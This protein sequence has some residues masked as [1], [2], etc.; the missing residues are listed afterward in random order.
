MLVIALPVKTQNSSQESKHPA[1][2]ANG[3]WQ[4]GHRRMGRPKAM[5]FL[6]L[7]VF[8]LFPSFGA[9][10]LIEPDFLRWFDAED[11][12]SALGMIKLEQWIAL[13]LLLAHGVFGWLAWH[14]RRHEPFQEIVDGNEPNPNHDLKKLY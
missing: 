14:Y 8:W 10:W 13:A 4:D 7:S 12:L 11:L 3:G 1:I 2:V 9:F 6:V 5:L